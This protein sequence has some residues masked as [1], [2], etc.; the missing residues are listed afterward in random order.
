M[1]KPSELI[2]KRKDKFN[3]L[4]EDNLQLFPND[5]RVT[6]TIDDIK[7]LVE[8]S[9]EAIKEDSPFFHV[10]GRMVAINQFG[11]TTFIRFR[12]RTGQLQAYIR[13]D[14]VGD[15]AYQLFRQ[16]VIEVGNQHGRAW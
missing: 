1:E 3:T 10:A 16:L 13:K 7:A 12:D 9:A 8:E 5:F 4:R 6:H 2:Q 11:K 14:K 15:E